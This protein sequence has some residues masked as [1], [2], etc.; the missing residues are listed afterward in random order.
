MGLLDAMQ[1]R[2]NSIES[3]TKSL[4]VLNFDFGIFRLFLTGV[5]TLIHKNQGGQGRI[6]SKLETSKNR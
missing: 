1:M 3:Y 6:Y 2:C 4:F 5:T